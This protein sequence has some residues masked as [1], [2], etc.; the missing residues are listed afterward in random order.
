V[1]TVGIPR[2]LFYYYY[3]PLWKTFFAGLGA[4]VVV[5]PVTNRRIVD[6]GILTAVD[7]ACLPVKVY[8]GHVK[9][10]CR[11]GVDFIFAP[12]L[13]SVEQRCYICP[14]FMGIPDMLRAQVPGLPPLIDIKIDVTRGE[15]DLKRNM[16][17]VGALFGCTRKAVDDAYR[18]GAEEM[19]RFHSIARSGHPLNDAIELWEK[20][21]RHTGYPAC[22]P[23]TG[24]GVAG[25]SQETAAGCSASLT[26]GVLGHGYS[27]YDPV[28]S[29]DLV[30]RLREMGCKVVTPE[31]LDPQEVENQA[32]TLPKRMFW[33]LGKK[34]IGS[35][36]WMEQEASIDGVIYLACFG[37][38]PDS[39]VG[40]IVERRVSHTP[41]MLLTVD[42]HTGE[43]GIMTR[44]EAFCDMIT[45]RQRL[46]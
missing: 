6:D 25:G 38:G 1:K 4:R 39:L 15:R 45:R 19:K 43:A 2:G 44:L 5:S 23:A 16:Y 35:G 34:M 40:E 9:E 28:I 21:N 7:E 18:A 14:K 27:V 11:Q 41:F 37:C 33:S 13:V 30:K 10:L 8:Y 12:R 31:M 3:Y 36:L 20:G 26:V 17:Q 24:T 29:M 22:S 32:S 46:A 42:E